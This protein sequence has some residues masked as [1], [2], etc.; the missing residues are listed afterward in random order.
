MG[1]PPRA[2]VSPKAAHDPGKQEIKIENPR[3]VNGSQTLHSIRD[4]G[5]P[6]LSTRVMVRIIEVP[7]LSPNEFSAQAAKR[8]DVI[9]KISVRSNRQNPIKKWNLVSNDDFQHDLA[10]FFR[11]RRL[12]YERRDR[13]WS[14]RR[15]ELKSLGISRGPNI[16]W[17]AQLISSYNWD[18]KQLG[19]VPAK[20][21]LGEL[22]DSKSYEMIKTTKPE[23]AYQLYFLGMVLDDCVKELASSKQ[24]VEH[25]AW[26]GQFTLFA[27]CLKAL[28][29]AGVAFGEA[30]V[31]AF[32]ERA[33]PTYKWLT[34]CKQG[35]DHIRASYRN[36]TKK[37]RNRMRQALT[38]TNYFKSQTYIAKI[39]AKPV[40]QQM[41]KLARQL[42]RPNFT[43]SK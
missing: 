42:S 24:Y 5:S 23:L 34:F 29:S 18:K 32:L 2:I 9:D 20:A 38:L 41:K 31:T 16:K 39:L 14:Y 25:F 12:Y 30:N 3:I 36:E 10:R 37:Y 13:E 22:F 40:P 26:Q 28:Q 11:K 7:P 4:V 27:L 8:R 21:K 19:P 35:I 6:S 33:T 1:V 15:T 43:V 17:L